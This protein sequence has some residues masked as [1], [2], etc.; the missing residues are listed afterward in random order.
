MIPK[1]ITVEETVKNEFESVVVLGKNI[2]GAKVKFALLLHRLYH[3]EVN[4]LKKYEHLGWGNGEEML[5]ELAA[6]L[7]PTTRTFYNW[8]S[9]LSLEEATVLAFQQ[10]ISKCYQAARL[11]RVGAWKPNLK[12]AW[13]DLTLEEVKEEVRKTL[14]PLAEHKRKLT[15]VIADTLFECWEAQLERIRQQ[16]GITDTAVVLEY[17]LSEIQH[18]TNE[19]LREAFGL[20]RRVQ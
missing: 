17:M 12:A 10:D 16:T 6:L 20:A 4:G 5:E 18:L 13:K 3:G 15:V 8:R 9:I 2:Q 19:S 7:Q 14:S 11:Q 1:I